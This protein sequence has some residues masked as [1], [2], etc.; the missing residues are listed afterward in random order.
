MS[1]LKEMSDFANDAMEEVQRSFLKKKPI[2]GQD[3]FVT[4]RQRNSP[5]IR[6]IVTVE[7]V[8]TRYFTLKDFAHRRFYVDSKR[9]A[10]TFD[11]HL[12]LYASSDCYEHEK[13]KQDLAYQIKNAIN[14][15][16]GG[17]LKNL[18]MVELGT[19]ANLVLKNNNKDEVS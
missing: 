1:D 3:L 8:G 15:L 6:R 18:T 10:D 9:E 11:S 2:A 12:T 17:A 4:E 16:R 13:D 5:P 14:Q 19:I 7:K